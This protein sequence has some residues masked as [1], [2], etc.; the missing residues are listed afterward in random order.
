MGSAAEALDD[1]E[2]EE[3]EEAEE[4]SEDTPA[5]TAGEPPAPAASASEDGAD[6]GEYQFVGW[7]TPSGAR[8]ACQKVGRLAMPKTDQEKK[9]VLQA[10]KRAIAAGD[11]EDGWPRNAV[12]LAGRWNTSSEKWEWDD[13]TDIPELAGQK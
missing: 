8:D 9:G 4:H 13:S 12:W 10:V 5:P 11:M 7:E 2:A 6:D 3:A 1:A